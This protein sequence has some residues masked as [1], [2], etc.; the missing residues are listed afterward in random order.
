MSEQKLGVQVNFRSNQVSSDLIIIFLKM[1]DICY[2]DNINL[3]QRLNFI[4]ANNWFPDRDATIVI[5]VIFQTNTHNFILISP[6]VNLSVSHF[7]L[8]NFKSINF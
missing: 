1:S 8:L 2:H 5:I 6:V 7:Y 4:Y 3:I